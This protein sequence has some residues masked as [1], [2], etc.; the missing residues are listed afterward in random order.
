MQCIGVVNEVHNNGACDERTSQIFHRVAG[1]VIQE[2][3]LNSDNHA[4]KRL[5]DR[6]GGIDCIKCPEGLSRKDIVFSNTD[7]AHN[8]TLDT[9]RRAEE[10]RI[11]SIVVAIRRRH[12]PVKCV[13]AVGILVWCS[14]PGDKDV[15]RG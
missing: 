9:I 5:I 1:P 10:K 7:G 14:E 12:V 15:R 6:L 4:L 11:E 2:Q 13:H 3:F 8:R